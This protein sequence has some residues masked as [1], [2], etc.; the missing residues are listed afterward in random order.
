MEEI[1]RKI[2]QSIN[3]ITEARKVLGSN[4]FTKEAETR[5]EALDNLWRCEEF[6]TTI[7]EFTEDA[8]SMKVDEAV[9]EQMKNYM[10][11]TLD[12]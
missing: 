11:H 6:A 8:M 2:G 4:C 3:A 12:I 5:A 9:M 1:R 10:H 7:E